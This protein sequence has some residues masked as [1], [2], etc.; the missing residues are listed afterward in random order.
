[1]RKTVLLKA[2]TTVKV[3]VRQVRTPSIRQNFNYYFVHSLHGVVV[4]R[5]IDKIIIKNEDECIIFEKL[6][7]QKITFLKEF[8]FWK[9]WSHI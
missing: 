4:V 1:M 5:I 7:S 2:G 3:T 9:T 8:K 6:L